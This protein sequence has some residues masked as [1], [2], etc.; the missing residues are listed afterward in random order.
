MTG[1]TMIECAV[2][3]SRDIKGGYY[4]DEHHDG[5]EHSDGSNS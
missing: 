4:D 2:D 5:G 3:M 1:R